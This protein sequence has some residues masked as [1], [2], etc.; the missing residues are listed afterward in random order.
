MN[1]K[2]EISRRNTLSIGTPP[3]FTTK[4]K[5]D[6]KVILISTN[7]VLKNLLK[8]KEILLTNQNQGNLS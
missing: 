6:I 5:K 7:L 1:L 2:R 8:T 3:S 4:Q